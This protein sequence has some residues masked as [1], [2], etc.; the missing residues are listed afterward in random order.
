MFQHEIP[1]NWYCQQNLRKISTTPTREGENIRI[2]FIH[3][4]LRHSLA[5]PLSISLHISHSLEDI[6]IRTY[7]GM[8][9]FMY[10]CALVVKIRTW[11][12]YSGRLFKKKI[13]AWY[14]FQQNKSIFSSIKDDWDPTYVTM[15]CKL[16]AG[17]IRTLIYMY[18]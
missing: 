5:L 8:F 1:K 6:R 17:M 16:W 3:L 4:R 10:S 14:M 11:E 13:R 18:K 9:W 7:V 12:N 2:A 15:L